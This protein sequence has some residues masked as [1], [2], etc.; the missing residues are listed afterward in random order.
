MLKYFQPSSTLPKPEGRISTV[1]PSS[2]IAAA[3][4]EE[5]KQVLDKA[6]KPEKNSKCGAYEHFIPMDIV[7]TNDGLYSVGAHQADNYD[8]VHNSSYW[9]A[10]K[11]PADDCGCGHRWSACAHAQ[12]IV[13]PMKSTKVFSVKSYISPIR[14]SFLPR[15]F[16]AIRYTV[17][18]LTL[19]E[20]Y[21]YYSITTL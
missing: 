2:S 14:E 9:L 13:T 20:G 4:K 6:D 10:S 1:M 19:T 12:S 7:A 18:A 16:P 21:Y 3:N 5:V 17:I 11:L 15:K 8:L